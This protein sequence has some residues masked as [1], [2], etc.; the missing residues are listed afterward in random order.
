MS[1]KIVELLAEEDSTVTVGQD[2]LRIEPGEGA[3]TAKD[4]AP[5]AKPEGGA[6]SEP[7]NPEEGNKADAAPEAK[8]EKGASEEVKAKQDEKAPGQAAPAPQKEAPKPAPKESKKESESAPAP[9]KTS[10]SRNETR[11]CSFPT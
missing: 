11:V 9:A 10:G 2:L 6:R 8:K 4:E 5:K 7:K 3:S 1:G